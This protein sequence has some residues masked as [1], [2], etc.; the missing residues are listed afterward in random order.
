MKTKKITYLA[1]LTAFIIGAMAY[2]FIQVRQP[3]IQNKTKTAPPPTIAAAQL[4][5]LGTWIRDDDTTI[6]IVFEQSGIVKMYKNN[7]ENFSGNYTI[8]TS[9]E[10]ETYNIGADVG[11]YLKTKETSETSWTCQYINGINEEGDHILSLGDKDRYNDVVY[12][13]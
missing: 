5:I 10:G 9:C 2:G 4:A 8:A 12:I 6:K 11:L 13:K 7:V 3:S 1:V